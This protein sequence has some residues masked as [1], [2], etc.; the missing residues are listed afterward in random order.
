MIL[1]GGDL[2]SAYFAKNWSSVDGFE[3]KIEQPGES[4]SVGHPEI[5]PSNGAIDLGIR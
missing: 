5:H 4:S 2:Y 3:S 1:A